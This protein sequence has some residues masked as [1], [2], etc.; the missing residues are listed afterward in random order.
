MKTL[1]TYHERTGYSDIKPAEA[2]TPRLEDA[3]EA[4][5]EL[6]AYLRE[7]HGMTHE[8]AK[9]ICQRWDVTENEYT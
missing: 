5:G 8:Q 7:Q 3:A 1:Q 4:I 9:S 2:Y 6:L